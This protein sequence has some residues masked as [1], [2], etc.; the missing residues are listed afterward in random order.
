MRPRSR[1]LPGQSCQNDGHF[2][3][4]QP[5]TK[6][7]A[8][9]T[10]ENFHPREPSAN[11][12]IMDDVHTPKTIL[13]VD[14]DLGL[15]TL[16]QRLLRRAGYHAMTVQTGTQAL[17]WLSHRK[18]DLLLLDLRM[19]DMNGEEL[20]QTLK[21][22]E[23]LIPFIVVT[24]KG[25]EQL[26]VKM[27]KCGARDYVTKDSASIELLPSV[28]T[29]TLRQLE[30]EHRLEAAELALAEERDRVSI[31]LDAIADGVVSTDMSGCILSMNP[32][33]ATLTG[34]PEREALGYPIEQIVAVTDPAH[35]EAIHP[36]LQALT[37]RR[38]VHP[39]HNQQLRSR[40]GGEYTITCSASPLR[41]KDGMVIGAVFVFQDM[42]ER[43][44]I[45][46]E[47]Q[48][49]N[50]LES[51]GLLA[52]GIAHDFNNLLTSIL[53]NISLA[54]KSADKSSAT[55]IS[56]CEAEKAS[57]FAKGLTQQL[58]TFA[59][60][61]L[62]I[63][64][65]TNIHP[66]LEGALELTFRG[67]KVRVKV[68]FPKETWTVHGDEGQLNQAFHNL[69]L[70]AKQAMPESGTLLLR[71]ENWMIPRVRNLA[72]QGHPTVRISVEDTG[73]GIAPE[74]LPRVFDPYFT[75]KV[76]GTG[77]GLATTYSIIKN[78][79]GEIT[80]DS[81]LGEGT[82][83]TVN[84]PATTDSVQFGTAPKNAE[85]NGQGKILIMDDDE[86]VRVLLQ[87]MLTYLGYEVEVTTEGQEA[88]KSYS[89]AQKNQQPF[90]AVIL[91]LT[92]PGG[93]GGKETIKRLRSIDPNVKAIVC[94]GYSQDPVLANHQAHGFQAMLAK[95]FELEELANQL[96]E[97]LEDTVSHPSS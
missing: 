79:G 82:I 76:N 19:P 14:D 45:D 41:R 80:V 37:H 44:K 92:I 86:G 16:I 5:V 36:V 7:Q 54:K 96:L 64:K 6:N 9:R 42:T 10:S 50:K 95:P 4:F 34:C 62:P 46:Q 66:L 67:T 72:E 59:K 88:L 20:I 61:G 32:V 91:D 63:K 78:H 49:A 35:H 15:T 75:T 74:H 3:E 87:E 1:K 8:T 55:Y 71:V 26:A 90:S 11:W 60:G 17:T 65:P 33:A 13:I 52:G 27:L 40:A 51:L 30:Q 56:L 43:S 68:H 97:L 94:S 81:T 73:I 84:L 48:K 18:A 39:I 47:L 83:V 77:I 93:M 31:T 58:L 53:G 69:L 21:Q 25:D 2:G 23:R 89:L 29:Q 38:T 28:V 57:T 70:N 85:R 22:R 12:H 24:G